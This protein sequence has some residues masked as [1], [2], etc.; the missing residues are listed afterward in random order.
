MALSE[1]HCFSSYVSLISQGG[2]RIVE[3]VYTMKSS[4]LECKKKLKKT[5]KFSSRVSYFSLY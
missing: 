1:A 4:S 2:F 5:I 3:L